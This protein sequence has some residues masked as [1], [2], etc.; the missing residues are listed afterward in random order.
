MMLALLPFFAAATTPELP[1]EV[2]AGRPV[3]SSQL[4][5]M[6]FSDLLIVLIVAVLLMTALICWAVFLRKPKNE[7]GRTR[8]Y[9][10]RPTEEVTEDGLIRKRKRRKEKRR[11]HRTR[12]PTLSE[13]GGLPPPRTEP[14]NP[15]I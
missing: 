15:H 13:T 2:A 10:S 5:G 9:K 11:E 3:G 8:I 7:H 12:N 14:P 4:P 6:H 1:P